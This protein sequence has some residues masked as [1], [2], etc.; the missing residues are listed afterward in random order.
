M[1]QLELLGRHVLCTSVRDWMVWEAPD[2]ALFQWTAIGEGQM[3]VPRFVSWMAA[4]CPE[5][6]INLEI[7]SNSQRPIP[8]LIPE[9]WEVYPRLR[10]ADLAPFLGLCRRGRPVEVE[11]PPAGVAPRDFE[12]RHQHAELERS[13]AR[14]RQRSAG[15]K[16]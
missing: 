4:L 1:H 10:A 13:I 8:F 9:F 11:I 14:M 2:G 12:Q 6:P 5:A 7:I 3:D 16:A 15:R